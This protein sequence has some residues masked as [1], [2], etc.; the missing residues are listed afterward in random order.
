MTREVVKGIRRRLTR[1]TQSEHG[2]AWVPDGFEVADIEVVVDLAQIARH[3]GAQAMAN[4]SGRSRY[5]KG[6]V[7]V[8]VLSRRKQAEE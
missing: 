5:M 4:K 7:I 1:K 6:A 2:F 3:L 8:N